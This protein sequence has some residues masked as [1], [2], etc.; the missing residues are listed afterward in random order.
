MTDKKSFIYSV[1]IGILAVFCLI[2]LAAE[3]S[4]I[5][6]LLNSDLDQWKDGRL[7]HWVYVPY[8]ELE[9]KKSEEFYE[10]KPVIEVFH[11]KLGFLQQDFVPV[12]SLRPGDMLSVSAMVRSD[13]KA[14]VDLSFLLVY[15][16]GDNVQ[17]KYKRSVYNGQG[18]WQ[19]FRATWI[20]SAK[21]LENLSRVTVHFSLAK[22]E[23]AV[24]LS[25][26]EASVVNVGLSR[27]AVSPGTVE[28]AWAHP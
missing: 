17:R 1:G 4:T 7:A 23:K 5:P 24:Q 27:N 15:G 28:V 16:K 22:A 18:Q 12:S 20:V 26:F 13:Q 2:P 3:E 19:Q 14:D 8:S 21:D 10:G 6:R 25:S 11:S 9:I